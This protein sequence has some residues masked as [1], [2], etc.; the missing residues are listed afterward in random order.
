MDHPS[1]SARL[2]ARVVLAIFAAFTVVVMTLNGGGLGG[3]LAFAQ[4]T[5]A[6]TGPSIQFINPSGETGAE[7]PGTEVSGQSDG[8]NATYHLVAWTRQLPANPTAEFKYQSGSNPEITIGTASLRG[9]DTY[10]LNWNVSAVTDGTYTLKAILYSSGQEVARDEQTIQMNDNSED[11]Q[12]STTEDQGATVEMTYP[13][14]AGSFGM[15]RKPGTNDAYSGVIDVSFS[16]DTT[17]IRAYYSTSSPGS[18]PEWTSC[19]TETDSEAADGVRCTLAANTSPTSV[20]AVAVAADN[21]EETQIVPPEPGNASDSGDAHRLTGYVQTPTT[22]SASPTTQT[23]SD[24]D[25]TTTG[26]QFPCSSVIT[27]TLVDQNSRPVAGANIDVHA[28]GPT[29]N[30]FFDDTDAS[31]DNTSSHQPPND[32]HGQVEGTVNCESSANPRPFNNTSGN[33]QAEHEIAGEGDPKHIE[34]AMA[35]TNDDGQ[36]RFQLYNFSTTITGGTQFTAYYDRNDDDLYCSSE[37]AGS[38]SIGW[39]TAAPTPSGL[40]ADNTVCPE[41]TA[42]PS[43]SATPTPTPTPTPSQS[44]TAS[45]EP[46]SSPTPGDEGDTV[47]S[48]PCAGAE[49]GSTTD[50]ASGGQIIVGTE[51]DDVLTGTNGNDIICGLGGDDVINARGGDDI[52]TGDAGNDQVDGGVGEDDL[53]GGDGKDLLTGG[54]GNDVL[55]GGPRNDNISGGDGDDLL[56]G[57]GGFD[58]LKGNGG[59]DILRGHAGDD[60]LQGGSGNDLLRGYG[61]KDVIKGFTGSDVLIGNVANDILKGGA[62]PD[63]LNG[64]QGD[65]ILNGGAGSDSCRPGKGSDSVRRCEN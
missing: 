62:G 51:G 22:L 21:E 47:E 20:T 32:N 6:P 53:D 46:S 28:A 5:P 11:A 15:Y 63:R 41:P 4:T 54:D 60:I 16:T 49:V 35:G 30:L 55:A 58:T 12:V 33:G 7:G 2:Q 3:G 42:T 19:G 48:G 23:Q 10:D 9:S 8:V 36:F 14:N 29:D 52:A 64:G 45:P 26:H 44:S 56:H 13:A 27:A 57:E 18:E 24:S 39:G 38:G 59:N 43:A 17:S 34:S 31:D 40:E 65:D 37:P 50:R 1:R 61:G 25:A